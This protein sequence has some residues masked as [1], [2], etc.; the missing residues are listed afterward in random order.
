LYDGFFK[1]NTPGVLYDEKF[2]DVVIKNWEGECDRVA[3]A[4]LY[5]PEIL[6]DKLNSGELCRRARNIYF[7]GGDIDPNKDAKMLIKVRSL[8]LFFSLRERETERERC[9][10]NERECV[11]DLTL[12]EREVQRERE[13]ER[14]KKTEKK[15]K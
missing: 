7:K 10:I 15:I 3:H 2:Y 1:L 4:N 8:L 14:D 5:L 9:Y 11:R 13:R 6:P 12:R